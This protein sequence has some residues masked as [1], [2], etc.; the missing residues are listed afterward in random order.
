[1]VR[2]LRIGM[3]Y[4]RFTTFQPANKNATINAL[5]GAAFGGELESIALLRLLNVLPCYLSRRATVHGDLCGYVKNRKLTKYLTS[6]SDSGRGG[7]ELAGR[8]LARSEETTYQRRIRERRRLVR[9]I[10]DGICIY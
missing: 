9:E 10:S 7:A 6:N 5:L 4:V 2:L 3:K 1:M 8:Y